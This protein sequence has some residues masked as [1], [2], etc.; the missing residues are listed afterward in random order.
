MYPFTQTSMGDLME[1]LPPKEGTLNLDSVNGVPQSFEI[2]RLE[3]LAHD[4]AVQV[5]LGNAFRSAS[6]VLKK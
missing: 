2:V 1:T 5:I 3:I 4:L 6:I